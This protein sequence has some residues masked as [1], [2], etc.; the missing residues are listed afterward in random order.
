MTEREVNALLYPA[1]D[2]TVLTAPI[3]CPLKDAP[4]TAATGRAPSTQ[5]GN[6]P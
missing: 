1:K 4:A 5:G 3:L 6:T 2:R